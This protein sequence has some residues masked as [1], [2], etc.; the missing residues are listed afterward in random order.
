MAE[1]AKLIS[2]VLTKIMPDITAMVIR[3]LNREK[4]S[5]N[6]DNNNAIRPLMEVDVG[7]WQTVVR[8]DRGKLRSRPDNSTSR[9]RRT[10]PD[11]AP[12]H[13]EVH[14]TYAAI[15][16]RRR[17]PTR[18]PIRR[19]T[20]RNPTPDRRRHETEHR[21]EYGEARPVPHRSTTQVWTNR[22]RVRQRP[23]EGPTEHRKRPIPNTHRTQEG[24]RREGPRD[25]RH[26]T[27]RVERRQVPIPP[28]DFERIRD[29][30]YLVV[31]RVQL[32]HHVDLWTAGNPVR[33][34]TDGV[35]RL[36]SNIRPPRA[37]QQII[38]KLKE[39][40]E[41]FLDVVQVSM[42]QHLKDGLDDTEEQ[43]RHTK[44]PTDSDAD[45]ISKQAEALLR[46]N[47][48][49][50]LTTRDTEVHLGNACAILCHDERAE[51]ERQRARRDL[52]TTTTQQPNNNNN[53]NDEDDDDEAIAVNTATTNGLHAG[54]VVTNAP[55][56][57]SAVGDA[58]TES[59]DDTA[60]LRPSRLATRSRTISTRQRN[61]G[62]VLVDQTTN[63]KN[64]NKKNP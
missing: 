11:R 32:A 27:R 44:P 14:P 47:F 20:R 1:T 30:M 31:R 51:R 46:K 13:A 4:T 3:Q 16:T 35:R 21:R 49:R 57:E 7:D 50:K 6:A 45:A 34:L 38:S 56:S 26:D 42:L 29:N 37:N 43:L 17:P 39:E 54:T 62:E 12:T 33:A 64:N 22:D 15:T 52:A 48:G 9:T 59:E 41:R 58:D 23:F 24:Y 25:T 18:S 8:D 28:N 61:Q 60:Y 10:V 55:P 2:E 63:A 53:D 19:E 40:G 5:V 36:V